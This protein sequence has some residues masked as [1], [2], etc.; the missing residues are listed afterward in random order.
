MN[1]KKLI[2]VA[3]LGIAISS[4]SQAQTSSP[5]VSEDFTGQT[6]KQQWYFFNGACLTAGSSTDTTTQPSTVPGCVSVL[7]SYYNK[8]VDADAAMVGGQNGYLGSS[9]KPASIAA[10][11]ADA[12]GSGAL[13]FTNGYPYG[14]HENGAIVGPATPFP[15]DQGVHITFKTL[16]YRGDK[17]GNG[18]SGSAHQNDGA[19]GISFYLMD[20][21]QPPGLGAWGGSLGYSCSNSNSPHDGLVGAYLGLG[22]D[23]F[24]NFLNG[25]YNTLGVTNPQ[26]MGDNTASGGG[27]YANRIGLRGAGNIA[28]SFLSANYNT[29]PNDTT[30]PY[31]PSTLTPTQ[32]QDAVYNACRTGFLYNYKN[33]TATRTSQTIMDYP[34]IPNAYATL[35]QVIANESAVTRA[36]AVPIVY[37]LKI[38][39]D[40]LLS[41]AYSYNGG[42]T[43]TIIKKA[44]ITDSNGPLPANFR[45]GFAGSTGGATNIHEILCFKATAAESTGTSG[46]VN[47]YQDPTLKKGTQLFL[48]YYFPS[49]WTGSLTAQNVVFDPNK[50]VLSVSSL[51]N[52]DARC[53]LTGVNSVTGPCVTGVAAMPAEAPTSRVMLTWDGSKGIP[54]EWSNLTSNQ[55]KA[56]TAGDA[57]PGINR[58]NYLRGDRTNEINS[59][60]TCPQYS[61]T[62]PCF[63]AR[64]SILGDIVDSSPNTAGPPGQPY[65]LVAAWKDQLYPTFTMPENA[66]SAQKYSDYMTTQQGRENVVYVGAN[67]GFVHGFRAGRQDAQGN[68]VTTDSTMPNDGAEVLAYMPNV[69]LNEIHPVDSNNNVI[70]TADYSNTQYSHAYYVDASPTTG[71][72]FYGS[73]WHTWL[74]GGLGGGGAA[75]YALDVTSPTDSTSPTQFSEA[76]AQKIVIGEWTPS[77]LTCV[78]SNVAPSCGANMGQTYGT[79]QIRRFHNGQWGAIFGNG[80][81]SA[82][83]ATGIYIMLLDES[84]GTPSWYYLATTLK[85]GGSTANGIANASSADYDMDHIVDY[86]YAGDLLG[87]IWKFD[88]T[89]Q[90]PATWGV[91]ASSPLFTAGQPITTR[92]TVSSVKVVTPVKNDVGLYLDNGPQRAVLAFGTGRQ[93]PQT[94]TSAAQYAT[95]QQYMYG[96]WD[97]DQ[98]TAATKTTAG[99]GWN[100]L[101]PKQPNIGLAGPQTI[102]LSNLQKQTLTRDSNGNGTLTKNPVCWKGGSNCGSAS[103]QTQFGWYEALPGTN[104]QVIFDPLVSQVDGSLIVNTFVPSPSSILSCDIKPSTGYSIGQEAQTGAGLATPL[105][106]VGGASYDS[107]ERDAM[108]AAMVLQ[109]GQAGD[110]NASYL[111]THNQNGAT[112]TQLNDTSIT[113]G[114]RLYWIQKR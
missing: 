95:G 35:S 11:K 1:L 40:G 34:A 24:G 4:V 59:S 56:L 89:S 9:T 18:A 51:I 99:T 30:K 70:A 17:G 64:D 69:V 81:N 65:T 49:D 15:T 52:W 73:K 23:E 84:N 66:S 112:A 7:S 91:T 57:T 80:F 62:V 67:D 107:V 108:G 16:T 79:P 12:N 8:Q 20:A 41:L 71:D 46:A 29:D 39:Q 21:S 43:S 32:Q 22:I 6:T 114:Q 78:N 82:N 104:E 55:Q 85:T 45:F 44:K 102:T 86:I 68:L 53:V 61:S 5:I 76:N 75:F 96:I 48:A 98:G 90:D 88:V 3:T 28:W 31:Y 93:I 103:V 74:V 83:N 50:N 42:A 37:D 33:G 109:S 27:Q 101:S 13:R 87:N 111:I 2:V 97:W 60:Q 113:N 110:N 105:F 72:V 26:S 100:G 10:Q 38:T 54:F 92:I 47:V 58:L 25:T 36:D 106:N 14:H 19:D 94:A 63:R 77:T